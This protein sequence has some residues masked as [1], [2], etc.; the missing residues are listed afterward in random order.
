[1]TPV[2]IS[3]GDD[4]RGRSYLALEWWLCAAYRDAATDS[5][6]AHVAARWRGLLAVLG[7][8]E[9]ARSA[10][11]PVFVH[12]DDGTTEQNV[13]AALPLSVG[14]AALARVLT[15]VATIQGAAGPAATPL[16]TVLSSSRAVSLGV[17]VGPT[18]A[19]T[20][21]GPMVT[22]RV[23]TDEGVVRGVLPYARGQR[24]FCTAVRGSESFV[25][26]EDGSTEPGLVWPR[27]SNGE[28]PF[29]DDGAIAWGVGAAA[30]WPDGGSGYV[31]YRQTAD[32]SPT[33]ETL[34]FAPQV[35]TWWR[36]RF[37][38][39]CYPFGVGSWAPGI[40]PEFAAADRTLFSV[41]G[42]ERGLVLAPRARTKDGATERRLIT[43]G[44]CWQPGQDPQPIA[45]GP[46]GVASSRARAHGWDATA[47][48]EADAIEFR[49]E[50]GVSVTMTCYYPFGM[51]WAGRSLVVS[52]ADGEL[53]LF[54]RLADRLDDWTGGRR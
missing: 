16:A 33:V 27:Q 14:D 4:S 17:S 23:L 41:L 50:D 54:E 45:L 43:D 47:H 42:D 28:L 2:V 52:T 30:R 12:L 25:V 21:P 18:R 44:W 36:D 11:R 13:P 53:L 10:G 34:P 49:R 5:A 29:G 51:A 37:Y 9:D 15:G 38:W 7:A 35:G 26:H 6:R 22:P 40:A 32:A 19:L 48:P 31:M 24:A 39:A 8:P 46:L 1:V 3:P 20:A